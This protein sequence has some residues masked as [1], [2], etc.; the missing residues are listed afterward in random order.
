M[1]TN[2]SSSF[3]SSDLIL[4]IFRAFLA[5][6]QTLQIEGKRKMSNIYMYL[7]FTLNDAEPKSQ[8]GSIHE[9]TLHVCSWINTCMLL[10]S[11]CLPQRMFGK[12][13]LPLP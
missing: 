13:A 11:D 9:I 1:N 10:S 8:A 12:H 4:C 5:P 2:S 7:T 3:Q 6:F